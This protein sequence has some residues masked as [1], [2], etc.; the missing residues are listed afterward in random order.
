VRLT[1]DGSAWRPLVH[2]R[3]IARA[4]VRALDAPAERINGQVVN[5]GT[6]DQNWRII[7]LAELV[8][9]ETRGA[10]LVVP[11]GGGADRRSYRVRFDRIRQL[12]PEFRCEVS[13]QQGVRELLD[14]YERTGL[15]AVQPFIRLDHLNRGMQ[16]GRVNAQLRLVEPVS[17][18]V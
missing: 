10:R 5:V 3:D 18:S 15:S 12:L 17:V 7:D 11:S 4:F 16:D 1:S 8:V 13:M 6:E 2:I 9:Q 14:A